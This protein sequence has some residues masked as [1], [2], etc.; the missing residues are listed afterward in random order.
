MNYSEMSD[1]E[2]NCSVAGALGREFFSNE[3]PDDSGRRRK[4]YEID[5]K[6]RDVCESGWTSELFDPCNSWADAGP[7]IQSNQISIEFDGDNSM[8]PPYTWCHA[9]SVNGQFG[10]E[11][12]SNPLR[13]AM[14]VFLMMQEAANAA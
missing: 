9:V 14:I 10:I 5:G 1:F 6:H 13:S 7:I 11:F 2:I 4:S 8:S 3:K 12:Q